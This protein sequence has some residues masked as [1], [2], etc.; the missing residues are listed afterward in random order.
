MEGRLADRINNILLS[1]SGVNPVES[2]GDDRSAHDTAPPPS[3]GHHNRSEA[4]AQRFP[5]KRALTREATA[6]V[7][8]GHPGRPP[9]A[10]SQKAHSKVRYSGCPLGFRPVHTACLISGQLA[11][12]L[13]VVL[14]APANVFCHCKSS[15]SLAPD[16]IDLRSSPRHCWKSSKPSKYHRGPP[17]RSTPTR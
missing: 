6:L 1:A 8:S 16:I 10:R 3:N 17:S 11:S 14:H 9:A 4:I 12:R 13:S 2:G 5:T 7:F 15:F